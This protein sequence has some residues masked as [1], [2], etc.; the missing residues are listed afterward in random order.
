VPRVH[1]Q[2]RL[3]DVPDGAAL[4]APAL[5]QPLHLNTNVRQLH[6]PQDHLAHR[7]AAARAQRQNIRRAHRSVPRPACRRPRERQQRHLR[8]QGSRVDQVP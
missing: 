4:A 5:P 6:R 7:A 1:R 3:Q 2:L 8:A